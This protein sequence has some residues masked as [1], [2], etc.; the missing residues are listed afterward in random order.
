MAIKS[1]ETSSIKLQLVADIK[2]GK[3]IYATVNYS[4][5]NK[6]V[7]DDDFMGL[8]NGLASLQTLGLSTISRVD[9][10]ALAEG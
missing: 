7:S 3:E 4:G 8:A 10:C 9:S 1:N 5:T 6:A 2:D